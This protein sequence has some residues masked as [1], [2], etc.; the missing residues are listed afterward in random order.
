MLSRCFSLLDKGSNL[1]MLG[2]SDSCPL[3]LLLVISAVS[4]L[5]SLP[6][7]MHLDPQLYGATATPKLQEWKT[8]KWV[9]L[10]SE[11]CLL[12][13]CLLLRGETNPVL[14]YTPSCT[15]YWSVFPQSEAPRDLGL[16]IKLSPA[17]HH[18]P[19]VRDVA[20]IQCNWH[21]ISMWDS[22]VWRRH[23]YWNASLLFSKAP[24][25]FSEACLPSKTRSC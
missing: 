25:S 20:R 18:I 22:S 24:F 21:I 10:W 16:N 6:Q 4:R 19:S 12:P 8:S 17:W 13:T 3:F 14:A 23:K 9:K 2:F 7:E 11:N 15:I 1:Y 5:I